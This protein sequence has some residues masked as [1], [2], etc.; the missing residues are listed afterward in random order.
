MRI[1]CYIIPSVLAV[2]LIASCQS[3]KT[4][5]DIFAGLSPYEKYVKSLEQAGLADRLLVKK[6]VDAGEN[7]TR[8][9]VTVTLAFTETGH[10]TAANPQARSYLFEGKDGQVFSLRGTTTISPD[11]KIFSDLFI[12]KD[13]AWEHVSSSDSAFHLSMEFRKTGQYLLR[14]QPE[15]LVSGF[16]SVTLSATPVLINPVAGATNRSVQ[17]FYGAPRD[18]GKRKHEGVDIFAKKGTPVIAPADGTVTRTGTSRLGGKV[19]WMFD[20]KREHSYYFAHLDSQYVQPGRKLRKGDT[21]GTV[22][23][24]GNARFT[25]PHLHFGIYQ[26]GSKD[27]LHFIHA[28]ESLVAD[29]PLDTAFRIKPHKVVARKSVF[30]SGPGKKHTARAHLEKDDVV[31]VLAQSGDWYRVRRPD[32][33]Q[34]FIPKASVNEVVSGRALNVAEAASLLA[35][36]DTT[37][38]VL[39]RIDGGSTVHLLGNFGKYRFVKTREGQEGWLHM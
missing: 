36:P 6:W 10:F 17:S 1:S 34:G 25:P 32:N 13:N 9:S 23:N 31:F 33:I 15:L 11:A 16:Y 38:L 30:F 3:Q 19:V 27:P 18:G 8:D 22:G 24:T 2:L 39:N 12:R 4:L 28:V 35:D 37:A 26:S 29:A 5:K 20:R 14:I 7:A 21:L